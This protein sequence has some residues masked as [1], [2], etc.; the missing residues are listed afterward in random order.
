MHSLL[1]LVTCIFFVLSA[2]TVTADP[3]TCASSLTTVNSHLGTLGDIVNRFDASAGYYMVLS[4]HAREQTL[5]NA[6]KKAEHDCCNNEIEATSEESEMIHAGMNTLI[7]GVQ[8]ILSMYINKKSDFDVVSRSTNLMAGDISN[9][10]TLISPLTTC[11][12]NYIPNQHSSEDTNQSHLLNEAF[13]NA[14]KTYNV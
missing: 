10:N 8:D 4:V 6:L 12:I 13:D 7:P 11:L 2:Y 14:K 1:N 3:Q 9:L 5:E